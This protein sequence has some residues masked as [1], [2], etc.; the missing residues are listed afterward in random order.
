MDLP[1]ESLGIY[2]YNYA[3]GWLR[4]KTTLVWTSNITTQS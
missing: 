3:R 1:M 4:F 2:I